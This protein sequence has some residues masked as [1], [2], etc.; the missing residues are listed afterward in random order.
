[1]KFFFLSILLLLS[2]FV[3]AQPAMVKTT[4][5]IYTITAY[6]NNILK[7]KYL[8][9]GYR[10]DEK[11]SDAVIKSPL[12]IQFASQHI[13]GDTSW[14]FHKLKIE[15][16]T[17]AGFTI[18]NVRLLSTFNE[19]GYRGFNFALS[20][21]EKIYGGGER[22]LPLDRRG[23]RFNLYNNPWYQ[24]EE[25]ADNLNYSVPFFDVVGHL[26][27][28]SYLTF[29]KLSLPFSLRCQHQQYLSFYL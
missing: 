19:P 21:G 16:K 25:G 3:M 24:Y 20:P 8:P 7:I 1:M 2:G 18:G 15:F 28:P 5:G 17:N 10:H 13:P 12:S 23:Y 14:L 6:A 29:R 27:E 4:E 11:V 26:A 9:K 22:A